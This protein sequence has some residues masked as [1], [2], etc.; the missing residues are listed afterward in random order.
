MILEE[1]DIVIFGASENNLKGIDVR[2]PLN[3][4]TCIT[5]K[6][7]SGKSS[8]AHQ[9]L[10][11]ESLRLQRISSGTASE[12]DKYVRPS[13]QQIKNLPNAI[14]VKQA[15]AVRTDTSSV[16]TYSGLNDYLR[17]LFVNE[18]QI[19]CN[20][21]NLVD[22]TVSSANITSILDKLL[23]SSG[24]Y[25]FL[26][27]ISKNKPIDI[28]MFKAFSKD[29]GVNSFLVDG[30]DTLLDIKGLSRLSKQKKFTVK[31][32]IGEGDKSILLDLNLANFPID[33]LQVYHRDECLID[34]RHETYCHHCYSSFQ[35]KSYSLF[36]RKQ[37][38]KLSGA[39][40]SC[41]GKGTIK[42]INY[43]K[44]INTKKNI[45]DIG[46][47]HLPNNGKYYKYISLQNSHI[48]TF[49]KENHIP[50]DIAFSQIKNTEQEAVLIFLKSRLDRYIDHDKLKPFVIDK[51]CIECN[52][53]GF[54]SKAR[55]VFFLNKTIA[56]IYNITVDTALELFAETELHSILDALNKLALGHL[57]LGRATSTLSGGELQRLKLVEIIIHKKEPL[58][59]IIDEP[60][61]GLHKNDLFGLFSVFRRI[62]SQGNTLLIVDHNPWI[63]EQSDN[64]ISIGPGAGEKGG[65]LVKLDKEQPNTKLYYKKAA[66]PQPISKILF[67]D[68]NYHN[69]HRLSFELPLHQL[70]CLVGV[71][72]SGKSSLAHYISQNSPNDFDEIIL[73]NQF[74]I[75]KNRRSTIATYLGISDSLRTIYALAEQSIFLGLDKSDFSSNSKVGACKVCTG[76]GELQKMPCYGCNGQK[77]NPFILSIT[78]DDKN[79]NESL[80]VPIEELEETIPSLFIDKKLNSTLK[81]LI[82]IGLGHLTLG[83]EI[84]SISGGE[85]QRVKLAKYLVQN[86]NTITN[87]EMHN[88][89]ILDEPSQGLDTS[90]SLVIL[91]LLYKLVEQNN[92]VLIIEHN[93]TLIHQSDYIIELGP[94]SGNLGGNITFYGSS[95]EYIHYCHNQESKN[96]TA[97]PTY[98]PRVNKLYPSA[99][100]NNKVNNTYFEYLDNIYSHYRAPHETPGIIHF[101]NKNE[102]HNHYKDNFQPAS[103]YFNPF[104]FL[105]VNSP[106]ISSNEIEATLLRLKKFMFKDV[107]ISGEKVSISR[108]I[109]LIDNYNSWSVMVRAKNF[110]QAFELGAGWVITEKNNGYWHLSVPMLS[111]QNKIFSNKNISKN[112][113]NLFFNKCPFCSGKGEIDLISNLVADSTLSILNEKFYNSEYASVIK[114]KLLRKLKII[115]ATFKNQ[116]LFDFDKP[117]NNFSEQDLTIYKQ[118]FPSHH[119]L[120]QGGRSSAKGDI[121]SWPGMTNFLL[122]NIKYFSAQK[123][124]LLINSLKSFQCSACDG[125]KYN[126]RLNYYLKR[127]MIGREQDSE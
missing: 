124:Q 76:L 44:L 94:K 58:L 88:L 117:F 12:Y 126:H 71:S 26:L 34:F 92:T 59:L 14:A 72:G 31:A 121:I 20:C 103:L 1:S 27:L 17:K 73:L 57:M 82:D 102:A 91:K 65:S 21:G 111:I 41:Q 70:V 108:A 112:S 114:S 32:H 38:S 25:Q 11:R 19:K 37:L 89:L 47:I 13:F 43:K 63:I 79:I 69:I 87:P 119:F 77:L 5:G 56:D 98:V 67:A 81:I 42:N 48:A 120:K 23:D 52:E 123:K 22:N 83:R 113:F 2:I 9:I 66:N 105:F 51:P 86:N 46:F 6:S 64:L 7:G 50:T 78:I 110:N 75:G 74:S 107:F 10:A 97:I 16:A 116:K 29:F 39:C 99:I 61:V 40:L 118:G 62:A 35:S 104:S 45:T 122:D 24:I 127:A 85:A 115:V 33:C 18:G 106:Y 28:G 15:S 84:P 68:I 53:S 36:T 55:S 30:K 4:I 93:E 80:H 125:K 96:N 60:S 3:K 109:Q 8:L 49:C 90:D 101:K 100:N 95:E 54:N